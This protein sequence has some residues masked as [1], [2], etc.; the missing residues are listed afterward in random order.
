[1]DP[2][3]LTDAGVSERE[4]EVLTL[5]GEHLTNA[6][7]SARLYI[8]VRTV[9]SHV[10]SLLRK[11]AVADRRALATLAAPPAGS[12]ADSAS[13]ASGTRSSAPPA[14]AG[15][16]VAGTGVPALPRPALPSPLTSF[17]G[18][19]A[20][21]AELA[22][23]LGQHRLVT[24][25]GPGGVGKTRLALAVA[26]DVTERY[27]QGAWYVDLVPVTDPA[28]LGAAVAAA[29]GFDEQLARTPTDTVLLRL[30]DAH[31]LLVLDNCEHV[32]DAVAE[33]V[34]RLLT[35][36]PAI[37]VLATSQARLSLP[38]EW[39]FAVPGLSL[40]GAEPGDAVTLFLD[41]AAMVG[42]SPRGSDDVARV[43]AICD[44]LDGSALA[45]EL[46][47]ARLATRGLDGIETA[48]GNRLGLLTGGPRL[49][50]R[51]RSLRSALDWSYELLEPV[52]QAVLRQASVFA[53]PFSAEGAAEVLVEPAP[54]GGDDVADALARLAGQSLL[55]VVSAPD[56]TR[57]RMLEAIR[58][59]GDE[60]MDQRDERG[61]VHGRHLAWCQRTASALATAPADGGEGPE[62]SDG[63]DR[64]DGFTV[65]ADE[66]RAAL[67]WAAAEPQRRA[68]AHELALQMARLARD[69]GRPN[70][71]QR[72]YELAAELAPDA[73]TTAALLLA[74]AD[75]ALTRLSGDDALRLFQ[76]AAKAALD[77][78]DPRTAALDLLRAAE[79]I[80]RS[81]GLLSVA[82]PPTLVADLVAEARELGG[83]DAH[84]QAAASTVDAGTGASC[85]HPPGD[86]GYESTEHDALQAAE[87]ARRVGD[88]RLES[89]AL[90]QLTVHQL[91][92]GGIRDGAAT[93]RRRLELLAGTRTG[94]QL[95]APSIAFEL[96]DALHMAAQTSIGAGELAA[97]QRYAEQ[98]HALPFHRGED[99]FVVNWLL[100]RA[101]LA[102][103]LD[104]AVMW[105][106]RLRTGWERAGRPQLRA[107]GAAPAAAGMV[108]GLR[109]DTDAEREWLDLYT[110]IV[111]M[112]PDDTAFTTAYRP[113][114][115]A[116]VALHRGQP[117]VALAAMAHDPETLVPWHLASWRQWYAAL[118]AEATVLAGH[119]A[120][121]DRVARARAIAV[122]NPLAAAIVERAAALADG[123]PQRLVAIADAFTEASPYQRA[124]TLVLAGDAAPDAADEGRRLMASLHA[125]PMV[126]RIAE[127]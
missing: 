18:R 98:R 65:V 11:L 110:L 73:A 106:E 8:S 15:T 124:R 54:T 91:M 82:S 102:G 77:A 29:L 26:A 123:E 71:S 90:D 67:H 101:A 28:Q 86:D 72:H 92:R 76:D 75:V 112:E 63:P 49:D 121:S 30:A 14:P 68:E 41:R 61:P 40:A 108:A 116:I 93:A 84:V 16:S 21:R 32:L 78:G 85:D 60:Q 13:A 55:V 127:P 22:E 5:L 1:V 56:G 25:V 10:S 36:C 20:E 3:A 50:R 6:E 39:A 111:R 33:L 94:Q 109:G 113:F 34:E 12:P 88:V 9:E 115:D 57:Y 122:D 125:A 62:G 100:V 17:V 81:S 83:D 117:D 96:S 37:A 52:D 42:W 126:E 118:W 89:A 105:G 44:A 4:A 58:Q 38:F 23:A 69:R 95:P 35:A 31:A 48:L 114:F 107:F 79:L 119:D 97:A 74:A 99:Q 80:D 7:I 43:T 70:E 45:I 59:Y 64:S 120:A 27:A 19:T 24:A 104:E 46:A 103:D 51:H 53:A 47:A 66:L 2:V 87:L